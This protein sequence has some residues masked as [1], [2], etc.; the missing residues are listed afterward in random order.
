MLNGL[1]PIILFTFSKRITIAQ[2]TVPRIPLI[3]EA[4]TTIPFP[5]I[6][7]YLSESLT[8]LYIDTEEKSIDVE[9]SMETLTDGSQPIP[10]QKGVNSTVRINLVAS[11]D[12][13]GLTLIAALADLVFSKVTSKE[14]SITY[15]HGA[16]CVFAGLLHSFQITQNA[17]ND[18]YNV[19][20]ELT[21]S[22]INTLLKA[23]IPNVPKITGAV[24][25]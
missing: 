14:Y 3:A 4:D 2:G 19:Q 12:S 23:P 18:L 22:N 11:R 13:I 7:I 10:I 17:E 1:D 20:I 21:R 8:G 16:V 6:P 9:T 15:L 25:L 24:P 5:P